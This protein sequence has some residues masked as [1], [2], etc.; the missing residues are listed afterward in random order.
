MRSSHDK[1]GYLIFLV[2][3][4]IALIYALR[5]LDNKHSKN[6]IWFVCAFMGYCFQIAENYS[7]DAARYREKF[8]SYSKDGTNIED[9]LS[10]LFS[11]SAHIDAVEELIS[12]TV[13][14]YSDNYH[15]LFLVYGLFFGYFFSRN[16]VYI[17]EIT[18]TSNKKGL[19]WVA[20]ALFFTLPPWGINGFRFWAACQI[21]IFSM[22][23]YIIDNNKKRLL[24]VI[25][26]SLTHFSFYIP[27]IISLVFV[28][29]R[30]KKN[31]I[32]YFYCF[33]FLFIGVDASTLG[34]IFVNFV[35]DIFLSKYLTYTEGLD[36]NIKE[37]GRIIEVLNKAYTFAIS[38]FFMISYKSN[39][40]FI[41]SR[42][43]LNQIF[44][45]GFF[46]VAVFNILSVIPSVVRFLS[47]GKWI[48]WISTSYLIV[49]LGYKQ[50]IKVTQ[51]LRKLRPF[52]IMFCLVS[53][54]RYLFPVLGVGSFLSGPIFSFLFI[55]DDFVI[56][57][58]Y[59]YLK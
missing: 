55:G 14:T 27:I 44:Q 58:I 29:L 34:K 13:S 18:K 28:V 2:S 30:L 57:N 22:L 51:H 9:T 8:M 1:G 59:Q 50:S 10:Q 37:G 38:I 7:G 54:A 31:L 40:S 19:R 35:P 21:F 46:F 49:L 15:I 42:K 4:V 39:E 43:S 26:A 52:I 16:I 6:I 56:G 41:R 32:F 20:L 23:P 24:F 45:Y 36:L 17:Y 25:L 53:S 5:N 47:I 12:I 33:S 3:P 11:N 48:L